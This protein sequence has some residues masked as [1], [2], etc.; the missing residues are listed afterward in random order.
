VSKTLQG[1]SPALFSWESAGCFPA[2][3]EHS[4]SLEIPDP[5][6]EGGCTEEFAL[7]VPWSIREDPWRRRE[8]SRAK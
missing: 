8:E 2:R 6:Q 5:L 3:P 1:K 4:F 7:D